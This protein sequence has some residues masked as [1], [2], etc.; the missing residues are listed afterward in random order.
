MDPVLLEKISNIQMNIVAIQESVKVL[1][2][3]S[4]STA[5]ELAKLVT[6]LDAIEK[7]IWMIV[8]ASIVAIIGSAWSLLLHRKNGLPK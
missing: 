8:G 2:D 4:S 5:V 6:R 3:H 7:F 1:N